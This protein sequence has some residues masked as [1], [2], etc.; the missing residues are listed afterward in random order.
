VAA[1]LNPNTASGTCLDRLDWAIPT[2]PLIVSGLDPLTD[3]DR[4][5]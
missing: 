1:S 2:T 5:F 3:M 4:N